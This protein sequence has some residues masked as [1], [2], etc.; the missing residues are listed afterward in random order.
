MAHFAARFLLLILQ[1]RLKRS[2]R[3]R[4]KAL[5]RGLHHRTAYKSGLHPTS[6][7]GGTSS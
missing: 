5:R 1:Q 2:V 6:S 7:G 4:P 3:T